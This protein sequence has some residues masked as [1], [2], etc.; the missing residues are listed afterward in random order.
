MKQKFFFPL[1]YN[2]SAKLLGIIEYKLLLPITIY[3]F[4]LFFILK[5]MLFSLFTKIIIFIF[6][7]LPITLLLNST[8][9]SEPFYTFIFA[10]L[11]H[12]LKSKIYLYKRVIWCGINPN[13]IA[14]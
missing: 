3:G 13:C 5:S 6:L 7:F 1:N 14:N 10:M 4:L 9:N 2:Y 8:V 12:Y 11:K